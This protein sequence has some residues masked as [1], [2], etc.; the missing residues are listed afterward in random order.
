MDGSVRLGS[1]KGVLNH[2]HNTPN[3]PKVDNDTESEP[4]KDRI[5]PRSSPL[6]QVPPLNLRQWCSQNGWRKNCKIL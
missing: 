2:G 3:V 1:I 6:N 4:E 5:E